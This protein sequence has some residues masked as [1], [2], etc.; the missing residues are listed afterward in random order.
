MAKSVLLSNVAGIVHT[1]R[2]R[3]RL[4]HML[5]PHIRDVVDVDLV[6]QHDDQGLPVELYGENGRREEELADHTLPLQ[7]PEE[8]HNE[9][10]GVSE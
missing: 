7:Y 8:T 3:R 2:I 9:W 6:L 4:D 1:F 5:Q 10:N